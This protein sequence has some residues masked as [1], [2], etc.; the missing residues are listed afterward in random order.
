MNTYVYFNING[1]Y[2][3]QATVSLPLK[4]PSQEI[5]TI[6]RMPE[7]V[8]ENQHRMSA[9]N[10]CITYNIVNEVEIIGIATGTTYNN[11]VLSAH[12][13][14]NSNYFFF[15]HTTRVDFGRLPKEVRRLATNQ[16]PVS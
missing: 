1:D 9:A 13:C 8:T 4:L 15:S 14:D 6:K 7:S 16:E 2:L 11:S 5:Q 3:G 10:N 12:I